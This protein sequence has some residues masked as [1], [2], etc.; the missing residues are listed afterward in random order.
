MP[1]SRCRTAADAV[2]LL[3]GCLSRSPVGDGHGNGIVYLASP[4][5]RCPA[6]L[7]RLETLKGEYVVFA[8]P[9]HDFP[10][11]IE[12]RLGACTE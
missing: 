12:Y 5:G 7:F 8:N 3:R 1:A 2:R 11:R 6:T 4:G 9:A 10:Q